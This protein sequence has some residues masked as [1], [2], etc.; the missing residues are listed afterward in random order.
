[1]PGVFQSARAV[2]G[3]SFRYSTCANKLINFC[4]LDV[5]TSARVLC[6][7]VENYIIPYYSSLLCT[8]WLP[9]MNMTPQRR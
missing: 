5:Q 9:R 8:A 2:I 6:D 1:M 4:S 7:G 3:L